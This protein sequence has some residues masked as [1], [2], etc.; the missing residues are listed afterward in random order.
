MDPASEGGLKRELGRLDSTLIVAGLF[1]LPG[2]PVAHLRQR[3]A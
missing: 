1:V 2:I 3:S